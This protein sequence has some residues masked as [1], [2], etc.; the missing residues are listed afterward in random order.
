M[1]AKHVAGQLLAEVAAQPPL[2]GVVAVAA[3]QVERNPADAAL[4]KGEFQV[5]VVA[6][7]RAPQQVLCAHRRDLGGQDDQVVDRCVGRHADRP[8]TRADV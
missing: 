7:R 8:E 3:V 1:L 5:R 4:G 6:H 2:V